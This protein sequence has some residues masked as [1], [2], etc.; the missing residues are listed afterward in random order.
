MILVIA[1]TSDVTFV[2]HMVR[3]LTVDLDGCYIR[4]DL[5]SSLVVDCM[6]LGSMDHIKGG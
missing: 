4:F 3:L 5:C 2:Q 6:N 1:V